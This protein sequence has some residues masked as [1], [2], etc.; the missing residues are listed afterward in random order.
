MPSL[1]SD[2]R[3]SVAWLVPG[4]PFSLSDVILSVAWLPLNLT[5][6]SSSPRMGKGVVLASSGLAKKEQDKSL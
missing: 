6:F 4:H 2:V 3:P 1:L 5:V